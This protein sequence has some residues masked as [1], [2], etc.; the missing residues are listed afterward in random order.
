MAMKMLKLAV[1]FLYLNEH[2]F[3]FT[4]FVVSLILNYIEDMRL[5]LILL[6]LAKSSRSGMDEPICALIMDE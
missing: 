4:L 2:F 5:L 1:L 6:C 3:L